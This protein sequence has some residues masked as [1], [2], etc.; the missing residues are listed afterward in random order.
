MIAEQKRPGVESA[1]IRRA[2]LS[3]I[4]SDVGVVSAFQQLKHPL[5]GRGGGTPECQV[6]RDPLPPSETTAPNKSRQTTRRANVSGEERDG[7]AERERVSSPCTPPAGPGSR[8]AGAARENETPD[9]SERDGDVSHPTEAGGDVLARGH[10][11]EGVS[12][13]TLL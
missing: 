10:R 11:R 8:S 12:P 6:N 9:Q 5:L 13:R 2:E 1:W 7:R 3:L 4:P